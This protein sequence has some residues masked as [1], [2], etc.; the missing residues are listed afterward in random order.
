MSSLSI[1]MSASAT[2]G[3]M[4]ACSTFGQDV[5][6][7]LSRLGALNV[8]ESEALE[9]FDWSATTITS[10]RSAAMKKVRAAVKPVVKSNHKELPFCGIVVENCCHGIKYT[11]GLHNQCH[12]GKSGDSDYCKTCLKSSEKSA[13]SKPTYGDIRDRLEGELLDYK[14]PTGKSTIC[15]ANVAA[16]K[17]WD[18]AAA[19]ELAQELG[20]EIP[21]NQLEVIK[22]ATKKKVAKKK[23][24]MADQIS[25]LV[26]DAADDVLSQS[27]KTSS[28]S[29][30]KSV[31]VKVSKKSVKKGATVKVAAKKVA[32]DAAKA[33]KAE[34]AL[35]KKVAVAAAKAEKAAIAL[36]KKVAADAA[37]AEKAA[38]ALT[39]KVAADAAKAEKLALK[40][41]AKAEKLALKETAK[42][43]KLAL[44]E[45]AK[46]EKLALKETAKAEK[47]AA[48][49]AKKVV[50]VLELTADSID[51]LQKEISSAVE[52]DSSGD[53]IEDDEEL[54]LDESTPTIV[55]DGVKYFR[56]DAYGLG[57]NVLFT[58]EGEVTGL[59]DED[60]GEIQDL[61]FED[62]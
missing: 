29:S 60:T 30:N 49:G 15:F 53:E 8:K 26:H 6:R 58:M 22:K 35:A 7:E 18:V 41:T 25:K 13:S 39:K 12:L 34:I 36:T 55:L 11:H 52:L 50:E 27:S 16:K 40:E 62:E 17:G 45:T 61:D 38:I 9:L 43:E 19:Q 32:A 57:P 28:T 42:A 14:D 5:V 59:Y 23:N 10:K 33:E 37:K 48:K 3:L 21:S 44:K 1:V 54:T 56:T 24:D 31:K 51:E 47:L 46:A 20:W 2:K 4:E